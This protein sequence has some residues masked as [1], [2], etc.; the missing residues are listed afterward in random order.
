LED[1]PLIL[2][3]IVRQYALMLPFHPPNLEARMKAALNWVSHV[4]NCMSRPSPN[5]R[6]IGKRFS[7]RGISGGNDGRNCLGACYSSRS[8]VGSQYDSNFIKSPPSRTGRL[9]SVDTDTLHV[10]CVTPDY[11]RF[12]ANLS[13]TSKTNRHELD[14]HHLCVCVTGVTAVSFLLQ[15]LCR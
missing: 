10:P 15:S 4:R 5:R 13:G 3:N 7:C 9:R 2:G 12:S 1:H 14:G 6:F 8:C 11:H